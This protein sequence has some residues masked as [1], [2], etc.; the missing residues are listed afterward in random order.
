MTAVA[1]NTLLEELVAIGR[2]SDADVDIVQTALLLARLDLPDVECAPYC[3]H[4]DDLCA[5]AVEGA[6]LVVGLRQ[7]MCEV[8]GYRG[9]SETYDNGGNANLLQVIDR[10]LHPLLL[11]I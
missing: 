9:D 4:L 1:E 5:A 2:Q 11:R 10:L 8:N 7:V 3:A 6:N